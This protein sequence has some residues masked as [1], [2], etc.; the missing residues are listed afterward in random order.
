MWLLL[1]ILFYLV[2][3]LLAVGV[4]AAFVWLVVAV[5]QAARDRMKW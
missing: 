3:I 4:L 5:V 2:C 1:S